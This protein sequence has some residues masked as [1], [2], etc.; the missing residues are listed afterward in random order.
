M[1]KLIFKMHIR[2]AAASVC[3][4]FHKNNKKNLKNVLLVYG[5]VTTKHNKQSN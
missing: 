2:I 5:M 3:L 4:I 1:L